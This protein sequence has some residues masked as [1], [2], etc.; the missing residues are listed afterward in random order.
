MSATKKR[1]QATTDEGKD[2]FSLPHVKEICI[3]SGFQNE[4]L[5]KMYLVSYFKLCALNVQNFI[6]NA[7]LHF[8][9]SSHK[10]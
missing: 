3:C 8:S 7:V 9:K 6:L 2:M 4:N 5:T 10:N 1:D